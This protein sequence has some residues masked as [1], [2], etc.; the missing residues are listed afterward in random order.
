MN[1]NLG[2]VDRVLR[3]LIG[4]AT[5]ALFLTDVTSGVLGVVTLILS[6]ILI[7]T[8]FASICPL[9]KIVGLKSN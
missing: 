8:S 2:V 3:L 6:T 9:Y 4:V 5:Y 1:R 7:L